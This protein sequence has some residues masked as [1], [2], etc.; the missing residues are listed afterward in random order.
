MTHLSKAIMAF[1]AAS[2]LLIHAIAG[3]AERQE[4]HPN[5]TTSYGTLV[6]R[7]GVKLQTI[8]TKPATATG[9]LPAILFVQ[10]LSC[11]TVAI[12]DNPR[13]GWS[14][15]HSADGL[16]LT[17]VRS[18]DPH[19]LRTLPHILT[20]RLPGTPAA[21]EVGLRLHSE[22]PGA[23]AGLTVLG[24]AYGW[25]GLQRESD[26]SVHLVHRFAA[27]DA[28]VEARPGETWLSLPDA[29]ADPADLELL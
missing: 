28:R 13:D 3:A 18:D 9:R 5:I 16:R 14:T 20:Q 6:L 25:I 17:C 15:Q 7:D 24:D 29:S 4:T 19:D 10:W 12:S 21:V 1:A 27:L 8:V 11:D 22:Q 26:G 2:S 23:R